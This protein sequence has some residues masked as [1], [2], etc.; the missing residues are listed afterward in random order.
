LCNNKI[1][2]LKRIKYFI[3]QSKWETLRPK[4]SKN[5]TKSKKV[6]S[7]KVTKTAEKMSLREETEHREVKDFTKPSKIYYE[8]NPLPL[9]R[10]LCLILDRISQNVKKVFCNFLSKIKMFVKNQNFC[11]KS[12]FWSK[13]H[14]FE[15]TR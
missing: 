5:A 8:Q 14:N 9:C 10:I 2:I 11:Q 1:W 12:K 6:N 15:K 13:I 4:T 3:V 7:L